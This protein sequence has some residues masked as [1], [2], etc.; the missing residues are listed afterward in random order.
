MRF[1]T[2]PSDDASF[3]ARNL[4]AEA[5]VHSVRGATLRAQE[6]KCALFTVQPWNCTFSDSRRR[7][8]CDEARNVPHIQVPHDD[9]RD[10]FKKFLAYVAGYAPNV[11]LH[12]ANRML[13]DY[14]YKVKKEYTSLL[15]DYYN[16]SVRAVNFKKRYESVRVET[17]HWVS[18]HTGHK[19][20]NL[21][22]HGSVNAGTTLVLINAIHF[23]AFWESP[24]EK[25]LTRLQ[26]FFLDS[27]KSITVP[28]MRQMGG[29]NVGHSEE[30]KSRALEMP[31]V[32][33]KCSMVI[34]L[35]D[36]I[37]GLSL[38]EEK[39]SESTLRTL[40]ASL[41]AEDVHLAFPKIS[42]KAGQSM[43]DA[44]MAMGVKHL[45]N[46]GADLSWNI[47]GCTDVF[48]RRGT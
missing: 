8:R 6:R 28:M 9:L 17:N 38:L 15:R 12:L 13:S 39:L 30:L 18:K 7:S 24:F 43:K 37:D 16:T 3:G 44:L 27:S 45:F 4:P 5:I 20:K 11:T 29:F 2:A 34:L 42:L 47:R 26:H 19:I 21:L 46:E 48:K 35:P 10:H 22:P 1:Q 36:E 41:K 14:Q 25:L 33:G 23:K 31:Y 40:L 32:G